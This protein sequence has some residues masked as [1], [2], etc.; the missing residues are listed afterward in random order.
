MRTTANVNGFLIPR[1]HI[2][3]NGPETA[4]AARRAHLTKP[5]GPHRGQ[6][7]HPL[8]SSQNCLGK[9]ACFNTAF[10]VCLDL[11]LLSTGKRISVIGLNQ[12]SWSPLPCLS[13]RHPALSKMVFNCA[14]KLSIRQLAGMPHQI[15]GKTTQTEPLP[16]RDNRWHRAI[17]E[18][19]H[20]I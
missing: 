8:H 19:T 20:A 6:H 13:N 10:A 7:R 12:I 11:I 18:S 2:R 9:P 3:R 17:L 14:V 16:H 4:F 1:A 15:A 5:Q